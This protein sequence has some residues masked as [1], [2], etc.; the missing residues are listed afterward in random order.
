MV[1]AS[2]SSKATKVSVQGKNTTTSV[3]VPS[4]E[5]IKYT[6][7]QSNSV[8]LFAQ[9]AKTSAT[10]AARNANRA[11]IWAEGSD[12][13]VNTLGGE[14]S[15]KGWVEQAKNYTKEVQNI[16]T[17]LLS[18]TA[19]STVY[20]N[21]EALLELKDS[22]DELLEV[23]DAAEVAAQTAT[24]QANKAE[25][26]ID[27]VSQYAEEAQHH[28][29]MASAS[30]AMAYNAF[31]AAK[32]QANIA[33]EKA[34]VATEKAE[35]TV[36]Q[37]ANALASEKN[38]KTSE[39]NALIYSNNSKLNADICAD[40]VNIVN[41]K[42][43]IAIEKSN[44]AKIWAEGTDGE[45]QALGGQHSSK[46]WAEIS[47]DKPVLWGNII[48]DIND[49][50]DLKEYLKQ[51]GSLPAGSY[52]EISNA[53]NYVPEGCLYCN[54]TE[55]S[56]EQ[57]TDFWNNYLKSETET[58]INED[59]LNINNNTL[60]NGVISNFNSPV[61]FN[62]N[63]NIPGADI[64]VKTSED[65]TTMQFVCS[66]GSTV[67]WIQDGAFFT[68]TGGITTAL[69]NTEYRFDL[70]VE[71]SFIGIEGNQIRDTDLITNNIEFGVGSY[72]GLDYFGRFLGE[73]VL[74]T[75]IYGY[76]TTETMGNTYY[77]ETI[78]TPKLNTCTYGEYEQEININGYCAK[79]GVD[80]EN[81]KFKV[82]TLI[83]EKGN[84]FVSVANGTINESLMDWSA[85]QSSLEGK[86]NKTDIPDTSNL[87]TKEEL[88]AGFLEVDTTIRDY[89]DTELAKKQPEGDYALKSDIPD[90][91]NLVHKDGTETISG[92]KT[93]TQPLKIQNGAGTGSLLVGGDVNAGTVTN[94]KR[95]LARVAVPTQENK[96]LNA[97]LLGFDSNGD[98]ALNVKNKTYDAVSFG[99]QTKISNATSPMSIGF[100]VAKNRN[101]TS[102][103]DKVYPL[104]MD[105]TEARFN[106]QPNFN[107]VNL[108]TVNELNTK[109]DILTAGENITIEGNTISATSGGMPIGT[110]YSLNCTEN[111]VPE[112]SVYADGMEYT[113]GQFRDF[114]NNY[115]RVAQPMENGWNYK[116]KDLIKFNNNLY[117]IQD[118]MLK[119][120]SFTFSSTNWEICF[121]FTSLSLDT[122]LDVQITEDV[123]F[124]AEIVIDEGEKY[125]R[126]K[127]NEQG[128][129]IKASNI[130][131]IWFKRE[132]NKLYYRYISNNWNEWTRFDEV[133]ITEEYTNV[134]VEYSG[135]IMMSRTR[136]NGTYLASQVPDY[137]SLLD[138]CSYEEYQNDLDNYGFC[139]KFG[140]NINTELKCTCSN[141][142]FS[143]VMNDDIVAENVTLRIDIA[144]D[145]NENLIGKWTN[146]NNG[147]TGFSINR[148]YGVY[149][150]GD[151]ST[152]QEGDVLYI[153]KRI[154]ET[155][156]FKVPTAKPIERYLIKKQEPTG[157]MGTWYNLYSDGW[158]E[159]G[160]RIGNKSASSYTVT[161]P[162]EFRDTD[163][164]ILTVDG[165]GT[166]TT[167]DTGGVD[168]SIFIGS[169][170]TKTF[171]VSVATDRRNSSWEAKGYVNL[172]Q[173]PISRQFVVV[174]NGSIN[175]SQMDWSEWASGLNGKA[176]IDLSNSSVPHIVEVSDKSLLPSWYRVWSDGWCEQGGQKPENTGTIAFL[177]PFIN[178]D[179][180]WGVYG[181]RTS[182]ISNSYTYY[183]AKTNTDITTL[184]T[185]EVAYWYSCGYIS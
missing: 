60:K 91:S 15:S 9:Q 89:V 136:I 55:Y 160:G 153:Y 156:L 36:V 66:N 132:D 12:T 176:N 105:S 175:Q 133:T 140:I 180:Y 37:A 79:F 46:R 70:N 28:A 131:D 162:L 139:N 122:I 42:T 112:G 97:I 75:G 111:Y 117:S 49:Q 31:E 29:N 73:I 134:S 147:T 19:V 23:R 98:D 1:K 138:I 172:E 34:N 135:T 39:E 185:T 118:D 104:E 178:T 121:Y 155:G 107:G 157:D 158:C 21:M 87:A 4:K 41:E 110:I 150:D 184:Q 62:F 14:H 152:L 174:A 179:Y 115:L 57:F 92:A 59:V 58:V 102:A 77:T 101:G 116:Y 2:S 26:Y 64:G 16:Q 45:V 11:K 35:V 181:Y 65:V 168:A 50:E 154:V 43:D 71:N 56:K 130:H 24:E 3:T 170:T 143:V 67:I 96:D 183:S 148:Y 114:W 125:L 146:E 6:Q 129:L 144:Y 100:C 126:L 166:S 52:V 93:F 48:G 145:E 80:T 72:D 141:E 142:N 85:W 17:A 78:Y 22:K 25:G 103:S 173:Y 76:I 165:I 88:E 69:P 94:G 18:N 113:I 53:T 86:A 124:T 30:D 83:S 169:V 74:T 167:S 33:T 108:A 127:A 119:N 8:S 151:T 164:S 27:E 123:S 128:L 99:G 32:E 5:A 54:G 163:I 51:G 81:E 90:A 40:K 68:N 161:F 120:P 109:Q 20:N 61:S 7:V 63:T 47:A 10:D 171:K 149:L 44:N 82:P 177:K 159:Q 95:K 182:T 137:I 38:A 84:V 106:V 13:E